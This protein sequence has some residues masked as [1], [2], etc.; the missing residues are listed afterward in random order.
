MCLS[1]LALLL[2]FLSIDQ[3]VENDCKVEF[4]QS[5]CVVQNQV[6]GWMIE[7]GPKVGCL[8]LFQ[9]PPY[10]CLNYVTFNSVQIDNQICHWCIGS[11]NSHVLH[12]LLHFGLLGNKEYPSL[13]NILLNSKL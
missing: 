11:P 3:L 4:S 6:F 10:P 1:L 12:H 7:I 8:F 5:G 13:L 9:L 2:T